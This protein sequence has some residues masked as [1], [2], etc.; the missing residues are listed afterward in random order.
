VLCILSWDN[1][2]LAPVE[3]LYFHIHSHTVADFMA[4]Q[5]ILTLQVF[6]IITLGVRSK[7]DLMNTL[8]L[9]TEYS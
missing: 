4:G 1:T 8:F 5:E 3:L 2:I 9:N 6:N 7:A